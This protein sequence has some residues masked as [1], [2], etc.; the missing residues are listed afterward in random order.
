MRFL[1]VE[2]RHLRT[3]VVSAHSNGRTRTRPSLE[4]RTAWFSCCRRS[5]RRRFVAADAERAQETAIVRGEIEPSARR[6]AAGKGVVILV[7]APLLLLTNPTTASRVTRMSKPARAPWR[8]QA[9]TCGFSATAAAIASA[10]SIANRFTTSSIPQPPKT[11][12]GPGSGALPDASKPGGFEAPGAKKYSVVGI[13]PCRRSDSIVEAAPEGC[14]KTDDSPACR[15]DGLDNSSRPDEHLGPP[16]A[17]LP[18][19]RRPG[20]HGPAI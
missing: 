13:W 18:D 16:R 7:A 6:A 12:S 5:L 19:P 4:L 1:I 15:Y 14:Q 3:P 8:R 2:V 17:G 9:S 10:S 11:A 20:R